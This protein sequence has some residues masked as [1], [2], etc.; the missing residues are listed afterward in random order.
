MESL[1]KVLHEIGV[2]VA[3]I[4]SAFVTV[5]MRSIHRTFTLIAASITLIA[6]AAY[7]PIELIPKARDALAP[8][9]LRIEPSTFTPMD[10]SG[11][12]IP[13]SIQTIRGETVLDKVDV[14][15]PELEIWRDR[16]LVLERHG[17]NHSFFVKNGP[18]KL[19]QLS[20]DAITAKGFTRDDEVAYCSRKSHVAASDKVYVKST[21]SLGETGTPLGIVRLKFHQFKGNSVEVSLKS[22]NFGKPFPRTV[23]IKKDVYNTQ[24]FQGK[25]GVTI[26]V[27]SANFTTKGEEWATFIVAILHG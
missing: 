13:I 14:P 9:K 24:T 22:E 27:R 12:P 11:L 8:T 2:P 16:S 5:F 4:A 7:V 3:I 25:Y 18:F 10:Q 15:V 26:M 23:W 21:W 17:E 6:V 19:G 1:F 20:D